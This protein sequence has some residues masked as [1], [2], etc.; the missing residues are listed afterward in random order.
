ML[1]VSSRLQGSAQRSPTTHGYALLPEESN[2]KRARTGAGE[3]PVN[4]ALK[5]TDFQY[6]AQFDAELRSRVAPR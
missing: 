2:G 3:A 6:N 4:T 1:Q 5:C